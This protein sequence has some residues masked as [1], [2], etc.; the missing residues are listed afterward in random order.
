[1]PRYC[2]PATAV[3]ASNRQTTKNRPI[4]IATPH[5]FAQ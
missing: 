1:L 3:V 2:A 5:F 4:F